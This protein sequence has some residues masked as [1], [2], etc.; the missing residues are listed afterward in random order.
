MP[1]YRNRSPHPV[2]LSGVLIPPGSEM[3][4]IVWDRPLP[5]G[6]EQVSDDPVWNPVLMSVTVN[7]NEKIV[8]IPEV[9][10]LGQ[11]LGKHQIHI[12]VDRGTALIAYN[13]QMPGLRAYAGLRWNLRFARRVIDHIRITNL[14]DKPVSDEPCVP[15]EV[16]VV[17]EAFNPNK[18]RGE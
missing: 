2:R 14:T 13:S 10:S 1:T 8:K 15:I 5:E 18:E 9:D 17:V 11:S 7:E 3:P 16:H 4:S 6:I 12:A